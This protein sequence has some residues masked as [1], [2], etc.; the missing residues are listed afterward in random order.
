MALISGIKINKTDLK[1][2]NNKLKDLGSFSDREVD[3]SMAHSAKQA[4]GWMRRDA[5]VDTGRLRREIDYRQSTYNV[6]LFSE[7]ID[8]ETRIDYAPTQEF[9]AGRIPAHPYFYKNVRRFFVYL[10]KDLKRRLHNIL[11]KR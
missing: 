4:V 9:G 1:H 5:P 3:K 10:H 11:N 8:P 6:T 2:L 7:A